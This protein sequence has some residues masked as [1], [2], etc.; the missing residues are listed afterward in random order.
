MLA[1]QFGNDWETPGKVNAGTVGMVKYVRI[2]VEN[3]Y[4]VFIESGSC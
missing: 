1:G 3:I 2:K 4:I